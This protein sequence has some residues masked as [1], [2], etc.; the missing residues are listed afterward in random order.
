M[1]ARPSLNNL[2]QKQRNL[3]FQ[4]ETI[5][6]RGRCTTTK[7]RTTGIMEKDNE[8]SFPSWAK[9]FL[10]EAKR[11]HCANK[12]LKFEKLLPSLSP[13]ISLPLYYIL[14][15]PLFGYC[16][17]KTIVNKTYTKLCLKKVAEIECSCRLLFPHLGAN[18]LHL[19]LLFFFFLFGKELRAQTMNSEFLKK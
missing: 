11:A 4:V 14:F 5:Q 8:I 1:K 19:K 12:S 2:P 17:E 10:K 16:K 18:N 6:W 15:M 7:K 13:S 9:K 3:N